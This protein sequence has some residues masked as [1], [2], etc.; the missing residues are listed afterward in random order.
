LIIKASSSSSPS[1]SSS[2]AWARL[3][4]CADR[5]SRPFALLL[6]LFFPP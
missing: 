2:E 3:R 5:V 4:L 6:S 1:S